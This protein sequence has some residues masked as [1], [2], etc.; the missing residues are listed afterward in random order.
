MSDHDGLELVITIVW[1]AQP[2]E[3]GLIRPKAFVVL[4]PSG[5][6]GERC[7]SIAAATRDWVEFRTKLPKTATGQVRFSALN[8]ARRRL[9]TTALVQAPR[10]E[11][12]F[13]IIS[14]Q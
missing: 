3:D 1:N 2:D 7:V 4:K 10:I 13:S 12:T 11:A 14:K 9:E 8:C 5:K 6:P